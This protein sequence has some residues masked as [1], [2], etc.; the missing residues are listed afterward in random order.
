MGPSASC[1]ILSEGKSQNIQ[2]QGIE[3]ALSVPNTSLRLFGKPNIDGHRRLGVGLAIGENIEDA[4]EK[5]RLVASKI[6]II[7]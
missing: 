3:D 1:A 4:R 6:N 7:M 2:Y 5:A